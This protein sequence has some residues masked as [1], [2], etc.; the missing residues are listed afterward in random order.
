MVVRTC[1]QAEGA[2][3]SDLARKLRGQKAQSL[4]DAYVQYAEFFKVFS[5]WSFNL[6]SARNRIDEEA[7]GSALGTPRCRKMSADL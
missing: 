7:A 1:L 3:L 2:N 6:E 4:A 5:G